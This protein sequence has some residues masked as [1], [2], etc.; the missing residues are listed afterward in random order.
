MKK[1]FQYLGF[2]YTSNLQWDLHYK[3]I[4]SKAYK[5]FYVL[6]H[7]FTTT[8]LTARKRLYFT[9]VRSH[10][11]YCS[12]LW[13][14]H[15]I[16]DIERFETVQRRATKFILNNYHLNYRSRLLQCK[17]LPLMYF[18][19]LNDILFLVKSLK[20]PTSAFNIRNYVTFSTSTTR[21]GSFNKL[22]HNFTSTMHAHH[23]YF[24]RIVQLL[25]SLPYIDLN[26][27]I[28]T[29]KSN[30]YNFFGTILQYTSTLTMYIHFTI[31]VLVTHCSHLPHSTSFHVK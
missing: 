6:R 13:R 31:F 15:L 14:P 21:S 3:S 28:N 25:D 10:L 4:I 2:T 22:I 30:L 5:M 9:L 20:S 24:N 18:L 29:I 16:K 7:T 8:S 26:L 12:P 23:F 11:V 17:I 1:G 27:T 19:E